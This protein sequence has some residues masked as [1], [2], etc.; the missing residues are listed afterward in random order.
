[1]IDDITPLVVFAA[2]AIAGAWSSSRGPIRQRLI[3][4]V[5]TAPLHLIGTV[6]FLVGMFLGQALIALAVYLVLYPW[7]HGLIGD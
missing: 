3:R 6:L 5:V 2:L 1:M 7:I 4:T